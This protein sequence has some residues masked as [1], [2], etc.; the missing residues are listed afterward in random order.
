M[1]LMVFPRIFV[2]FFVLLSATACGSSDYRFIESV[3]T[4]PDVITS[5]S[6]P[7]FT[8]EI[9]SLLIVSNVADE[10][11]RQDFGELLK[12]GY[13]EAA[14]RCGVSAIVFEENVNGRPSVR[15]NIGSAEGTLRVERRF[16]R[17]HT[18]TNYSPSYLTQPNYVGPR[19]AAHV[20][21]D[22]MVADHQITLI[23][24]PLQREIWKADLVVPIPHPTRGMRVWGA[25]TPE[26]H[27]VADV[28]FNRL[29]QDGILR[30]CGNLPR[31]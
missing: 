3:I 22:V 18:Y 8:R 31:R 27:E 2:C 15:S 12:R 1:M 11:Q 7:G 5:N 24:T 13:E 30:N 6:D 29:A 14:A 16:I 17:K 9:R 26:P 21:G 28:I 20:L 23:Y 4:R 25:R 10:Y 19:S